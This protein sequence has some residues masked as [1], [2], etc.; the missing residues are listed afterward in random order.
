MSKTK[1]LNY[2]VQACGKKWQI[3]TFVV[4]PNRTDGL[5]FH[6]LK[7]FD[8][9]DIV[10]KGVISLTVHEQYENIFLAMAKVLDVIKAKNPVYIVYTAIDS[11]RLME[12]AKAFC[13]EEEKPEP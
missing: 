5:Q 4:Y 13:V 3:L 1:E 11:N 12:M 6:G 2:L 7:N 8:D 9:E 10:V